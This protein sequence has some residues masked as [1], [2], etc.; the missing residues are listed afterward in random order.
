MLIG[1]KSKL[2]IEAKYTEV[3]KEYE[4]IKKWFDDSDNRTQVL[5]HWIAF[6]QL[7]LEET[8][9][10][11][12]IS[13]IPYQFLHRSASACYENHA[14]AYVIYQIFYDDS[15]VDGMNSFIQLLQKSVQVLKPNNKL[16]FYVQ[17]IK[18][19]LLNDKIELKSS[20]DYIKKNELYE[21]SNIE[22]QKFNK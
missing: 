9:S 7:H 3:N 11:S 6:M 12:D 16:K 5:K 18:T 15:T 13:E 4:I 10:V 2:A 20:L 19:K 1:E 21:F 14:N 22:V 8:I 17:K